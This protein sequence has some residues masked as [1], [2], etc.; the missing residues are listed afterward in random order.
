M[1]TAKCN[2]C[3]NDV[4][5]RRSVRISKN[6]SA[7]KITCPTCLNKKRPYKKPSNIKRVDTHKELVKDVSERVVNVSLVADKKIS[8]DNFVVPAQTF[9]GPQF[10]DVPPS[11]LHRPPPVLPTLQP[12]GGQGHLPRTQMNNLGHVNSPQGYSSAFFS[13]Q[14]NPDETS[15][16][17]NRYYQ[18]GLSHKTTAKKANKT[19][20]YKLLVYRFDDSNLFL[21]SLD[22]DNSHSKKITKKEMVCLKTL[23]LDQTPDTN[24]SCVYSKEDQWFVHKSVSEPH[25]VHFR[26]TETG[27][28]IFT[29][30]PILFL[31]NVG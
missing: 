30:V 22:P 31:V 7:Q 24:K 15:V 10:T 17:P 26:D 5:L 14:I 27:E 9:N 28:Y 4:E 3:D 13:T 19:D 2:S 8:S 21:T 20:T 16:G 23:L 1:V 6:V 25:T 12:S 18:M 11:N 29:Y